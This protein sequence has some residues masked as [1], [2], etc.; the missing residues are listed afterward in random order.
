MSWY[1]WAI[2]AVGYSLLTWIVIELVVTF[3]LVKLIDI[4]DKDL[5]DLLP[6]AYFISDLDAIENLMKVSSENK[7]SFIYVILKMTATREAFVDKLEDLCKTYGYSAEGKYE[8][9]VP[10][11]IIYFT[12]YSTESKNE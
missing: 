10:S 11:L 1:W 4:Y 6:E 9:L 2:I 5:S 12:H 7:E 8:P 3:K